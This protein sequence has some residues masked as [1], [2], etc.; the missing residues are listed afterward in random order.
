MSHLGY[1]RKTIIYRDAMGLQASRT[2]G[3][4]APLFVLLARS[5]QL[6]TTRRLT[7]PMVTC[8]GSGIVMRG[9]ERH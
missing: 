2:V 5:S 7:G 4:G 3:A 8:Q 9:L 6:L 1:D